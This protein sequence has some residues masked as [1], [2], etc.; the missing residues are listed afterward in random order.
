MEEGGG[1][2]GPTRGL[3]RDFPLAKMDENGNFLVRDV[4]GEK[5]DGLDGR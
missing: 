2:A 4:F 1:A 5:I 3:G